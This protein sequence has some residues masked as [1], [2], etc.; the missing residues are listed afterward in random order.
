MIGGG[1]PLVRENL[2]YRPTLF[3]NA[4][5]QLS[6]YIR[7]YASAVIPSEKSLINTNRKSTTRFVM[8]QRWTSYVVPKSPKEGSKTQCPKFEQ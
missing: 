2:A 7:P 4:N 5:F 1:R 3:Q 8:S 6:I